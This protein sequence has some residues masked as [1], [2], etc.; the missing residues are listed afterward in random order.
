MGNSR[1]KPVFLPGHNLF[2][3]N[4]PSAGKLQQETA[5]RTKK[6]ELQENK[7]NGKMV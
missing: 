7:K 4:K 6:K 5:A 1:E 2:T 3:Q